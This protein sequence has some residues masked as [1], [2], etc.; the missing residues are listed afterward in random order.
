MSHEIPCGVCGLRCEVCGSTELVLTAI[1]H[2]WIGHCGGPDGH[3][4]L[5]VIGS[6]IRLSVLPDLDAELDELFDRGDS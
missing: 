4:W 1:P 3:T 6:V 2:G 5:P